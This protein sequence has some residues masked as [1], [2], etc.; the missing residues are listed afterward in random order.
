MVFQIRLKQ[1]TF[2]ISKGRG[3]EFQEHHYCDVKELP[4]TSSAHRTVGNAINK[5]R[6]R[7]VPGTA[8]Q[9]HMIKTSQPNLYECCMVIYVVQC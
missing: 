7:V 5:C 4:W 2:E 9:A 6:G 8:V 1:F 3:Q